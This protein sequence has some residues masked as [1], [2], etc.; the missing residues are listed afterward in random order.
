M[1]GLNEIDTR[2]ITGTKIDETDSMSSSFKV[3]KLFGLHTGVNQPPFIEAAVILRSLEAKFAPMPI[4]KRNPLRVT[5]SGKFR[6]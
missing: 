2:H 6:P 5:N 4:V 3:S 1:V